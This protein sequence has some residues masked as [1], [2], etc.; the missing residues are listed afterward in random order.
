MLFKDIPI[1]Q[2]LMRMIGLV[3]GMVLFVTSATFYIYEFFKFRET[4][5]EKLSTI[6]KIISRNSTAALS[7]Y[8]KEDADQ[9][10]SALDLNLTSWQLVFTGRMETFFPNTLRN[11]RS[12]PFHSL[13]GRADIIF[14][15]H[16]WRDL[17]P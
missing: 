7:F 11:F 15:D 3:S 10:L 6:G 8:N 13:R 17:N 4:S 5:T 16:T 2:K 12:G 9:I 14:Q 1:Q